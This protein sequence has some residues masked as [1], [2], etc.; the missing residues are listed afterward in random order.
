MRKLCS[1]DEVASIVTSEIASLPEDHLAAL[2]PFVV[3]LEPF[4]TESGPGSDGRS[5]WLIARD[6]DQVLYWDGIEEE[7]ATGQLSGR[8]LRDIKLCGEKLEWCVRQFIT[9]Q[10]GEPQ[11]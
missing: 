4:A 10:N 2:F 9:R 6:G 1:R 3:A 8:V 7:F 11:H 5:D